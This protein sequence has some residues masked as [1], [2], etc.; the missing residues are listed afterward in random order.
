MHPALH[1]GRSALARAAGLG[2]DEDLGGGLSKAQERTAGGDLHGLALRLGHGAHAV[3]AE[4]GGVSAGFVGTCSSSEVSLCT[5]GYEREKKQV[6]EMERRQRVRL[7][8]RAH[9]KRV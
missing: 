5:G 6:I 8:A 3:H 2:L 7:G 1:H 4:N 9:E